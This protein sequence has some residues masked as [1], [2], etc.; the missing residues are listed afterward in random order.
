MSITESLKRNKPGVP[1]L[2]LAQ[3]Y[4]SAE[5][6]LPCTLRSETSAFPLPPL[7]QKSLLLM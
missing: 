1:L 5:N 4:P 7:W 6:I 2:P 3:E